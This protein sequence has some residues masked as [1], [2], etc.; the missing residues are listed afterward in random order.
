MNPV[1]HEIDRT[2]RPRCS[3]HVMSR[4]ACRGDQG[5]CERA[6]VALDGSGPSQSNR[7]LFLQVDY[8][9]RLPATGPRHQVDSVKFPPKLDLDC[10]PRRAVR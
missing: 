9:F 1:H 3:A 7:W 4:G 6:H 8:R 10:S 2:S 5:R